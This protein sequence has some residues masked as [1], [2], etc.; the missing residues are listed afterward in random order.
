MMKVHDPLKRLAAALS[1]IV[2]VS[3]MVWSIFV[4]QKVKSGGHTASAVPVESVA[5]YVVHAQI[6]NREAAVPT[7]PPENCAS[8]RSVLLNVHATTPNRPTFDVDCDGKPIVSSADPNT[9]VDVERTCSLPQYGAQECARFLSDGDCDVGQYR[10]GIIEGKGK[11]KK[12]ALLKHSPNFNCS[13]YSYD[14]G[15]CST[16]TSRLR[17]A[18][19]AATPQWQRNRNA[20]VSL[21]TSGELQHQTSPTVTWSSCLTVFKNTSREECIQLRNPVPSNI[22][23]RGHHLQCVACASGCLLSPRLTTCAVVDSFIS[24]L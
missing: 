15:D 4:S 18:D 1:C 24:N 21:A 6:P 8:F 17:G 13:Q 14:G 12:K 23:I 20:K 11:K 3:M 22:G 16:S 10:A 19:G 2:I 9:V 5:S 7:L